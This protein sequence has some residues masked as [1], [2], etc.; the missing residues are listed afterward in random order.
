MTRAEVAERFG[1]A[2]EKVDKAVVTMMAKFKMTEAQALEVIACAN[3]RYGTAMPR[4]LFIRDKNQKQVPAVPTRVHLKFKKWQRKLSYCVKPRQIWF[5]SFTQ[6]DYFLDC[7][8]VGVKVLFINLDNRVTEEVFD[9]VHNYHDNFALKPL[10]PAT[11]RSTT[12]KL[13]WVNGAAYDAITC[14]NDDGPETAKT[15][16]RS[17]TVQ[18][19]HV[20]EAAY[21]RYYR[22][23]TAGMLDSIPTD[24]RCVFES[25]G[26]GAQ[27]GFYEDCMEIFERGQNV[28]PGVWVMGDKSLH[29]FAWWEHPEYRLA[30]DPLPEFRAQMEP[31]HVQQLDQSEADHLAEMRKDLEMPEAERQSAINWR[32][33]MLLNKKGFLRD[34]D[35]AIREMDKEYPATIRHAFASTGSAFLSLSLIDLRRE[36]WKKMNAETRMPLSGRMAKDQAGRWTVFPGFDEVHFWAFP[37]DADAEAWEDRYLVGADVGGGNPDSDPDCVWVKDRWTNMY[38]AVSHGKWGPKKTAE[39]LMALGYFYHTA[40]IVW[41]TNNHGVGVS[42][43]VWG[44]QYPNAYRWDEKAEEWKGWGFQTGERSRDAALRRLKQVFEERTRPLLVPYLEF[45]KEAAAFGPAAGKPDSK[46]E[47]QNGTH[48]D[49]VI[50]MAITEAVCLTMPPARQVEVYQA[51]QPGTFGAIR[52]MVAGGNRGGLGNV[53]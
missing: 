18:R 38:V 36:E 24:G 8:D 35:G 47:G 5:T 50:S 16:G 32:R 48:D 27:G 49:T 20:T 12:R 29:F 42:L 7:V 52:E 21:M 4:L 9:R 25:T 13:S 19:V 37:Y 26:N 15:L 46:L 14:K 33:W 3:D 1:L 30:T 28:A 39:I 23:F 2:P 6:G 11:K 22:E 31:R 17:C 45:Y 34:P 51:A 44:A 10:L 43:A 40:K 53:L 41:E